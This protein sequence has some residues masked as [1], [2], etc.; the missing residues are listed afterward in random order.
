MME[1]D[2]TDNGSGVVENRE[3]PEPERN[4]MDMT[5]NGSGQQE[6]GLSWNHWGKSEVCVSPSSG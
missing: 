5:E 1:L 4:G 3:G 6:G 2:E